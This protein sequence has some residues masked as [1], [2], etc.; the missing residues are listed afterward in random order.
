M[1]NGYLK[2]LRKI[3]ELSKGLLENERILN[4]ILHALIYY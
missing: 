1:L 2:I 4:M 3:T